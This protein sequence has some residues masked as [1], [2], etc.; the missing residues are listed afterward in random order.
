MQCQYCWDSLLTFPCVYCFV[1][2][3]KGAKLP[4]PEYMSQFRTSFRLV[5]TFCMAEPCHK[6][7][8]HRLQISSGLSRGR[9]TSPVRPTGLTMTTGQG[10][11][12]QHM[13][14]QPAIGGDSHLCMFIYAGSHLSS[15]CALPLGVL[16][17][18]EVW[19]LAVPATSVEPHVEVLLSC[20]FVLPSLQ[21]GERC[22]W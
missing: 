22:N 4:S 2:F 1:C 19:V 3:A 10:I 7:C 6:T 12:T 13:L 15:T 18:E 21:A 14:Y 9:P 5:Y 11:C 16:Q 8:R 17:L 20:A